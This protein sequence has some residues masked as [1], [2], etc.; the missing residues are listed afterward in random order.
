M[1]PTLIALL[2]MFQESYSEGRVLSPAVGRLEDPAVMARDGV[3]VLCTGCLKGST[4]MGEKSD[5]GMVKLTGTWGNERLK[6]VHVH[7]AL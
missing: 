1:S 5:K 4:A 3:V 7:T 2:A 6:F